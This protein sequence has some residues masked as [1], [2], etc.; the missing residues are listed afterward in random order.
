MNEQYILDEHSIVLIFDEPVDN[1]DG[2]A[3]FINKIKTRLSQM[4]SDALRHKLDWIVNHYD[5]YYIVEDCIG[6]KMM[7]I[8]F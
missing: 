8:E 7:Y 3:H 6:N 2:F 5:D 1:R 4:C